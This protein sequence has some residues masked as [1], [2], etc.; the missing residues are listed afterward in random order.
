MSTTP[1]NC[2]SAP[3]FSFN[4][5]KF[6]IAPGDV[7]VHIRLILGI[8]HLFLLTLATL[9]L[10]MAAAA[11][12]PNI[13][14]ITSEDNSAHWLGCYGNT[15]TSTPRLDALARQGLMFNHAYANGPVCAVA[16]STILNG[17][18]AVTQ[19]TQHMRSRHPIPT[20]FAGHATH[21]RQLGYYCTNNSKTDYNFRGDDAAIWDECSVTAHYR[22]RPDRKPFFA[23]FNVE[24]THES[25]LFPEQVTV[26]RKNG[27]LPENTR[28]DPA[29]LNVPPHLPDLPAVRSDI[30]IY[31][32]CI[33][34]MDH[35][36]GKLLDDLKT[37]GLAEDT[38]VFYYSDHGGAMAR[39]KR[40]LHDTGTR[41]P[42]IVYFPEKWRHL[43]PFKPGSKV[44]E[45]V[46]FVDLAPT[47]LSLCG[48]PTPAPMQGRAFLGEHRQPPA[49][50]DLVLLY[51]DRFDELEGMR[52][53]ITDGRHRYIRCFSPQLPG[54]P[55][56]TYPLGQPSWA[57][58]RD[59]AEEGTLPALHTAMWKAPQPM[60]M[61]FDTGKDPWEL[62]NLADD[63]AHAEI[64]T[65]MRARLRS[66]MATVFDTGLVPE[67]MWRELAGKDT[68]HDYIRSADFDLDATLDLAF[69]ATS[70][71]GWNEPRF[72]Q[73]LESKDPIIRY[74]AATACLIHAKKATVVLDELIKSLDDPQP[75]IR[76]VA[77]EA[78]IAAGRTQSGKDALLATRAL[79]MS[80]ECSQW[81]GNA[82]KRAKLNDP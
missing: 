10:C 37:A 4:S 63:P 5:G 1:Q 36:V 62:R 12:R 75:L 13:L 56:A 9:S 57:A 42:L 48:Q 24:T 11:E 64:L 77:A 27:T 55:Y 47:L 78:L 28:L 22:N 31:H 18:H 30:A 25:R 32:D 3:E 49:A 59:A 35:K 69:A 60:E 70:P 16:R 7:S 61:L 79:R 65:A 73:A 44:D 20:Q 46:S 72:I 43:S 40:Y 54:A 33:S 66:K 58:W 50:D 29:R 21:L 19:G 14:W 39:A 51:A 34:A 68:I 80:P 71:D 45:L 6:P 8:R 41:V 17:A 52:R 53:A 15:E 67:P 38:I 74:W 82:L 23:I 2:F 76:I 26:N 81:L